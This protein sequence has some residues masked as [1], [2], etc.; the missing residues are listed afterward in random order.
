MLS[1]QFSQ[2][3]DDKEKTL[4]DL[5]V[6]EKTAHSDALTGLPN[7]HALVK[8]VV[9]L[10]LHGSL[11]FIDLDGLKFYNDTYGHERGDE[12]LCSFAECYQQSLGTEVKLYRL[13]GDEF[14]AL[15]HKGDMP[16]IANALEEALGA[17][18]AIGFEFSGASA[19]SVYGYEAEN[20]ASLMRMADAR[21]YENK[22][23]RKST[24]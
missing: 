16:K 17:M 8:E 3:H 11:T 13:G 24:R 23:L 9:T 4:E 5:V 22:R 19:G 6:S 15:S 1:Y 10:P 14:A 12:L 18:K 7:R 2:L 21:M 20:I